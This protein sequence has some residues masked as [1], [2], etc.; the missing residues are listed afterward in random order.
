MAAK[1]KSAKSEEKEKTEKA[2]L[3]VNLPESSSFLM[4]VAIVV[5]AIVIS[6]AVIYTGSQITDSGSALGTKE[7]TADE[8][9][10]PSDNADNTIESEVAATVLREFETFTEYDTEIC[11]DDGKPIVYLFSTTWCPHCSWIKDTFESWAKENT[12]KV[13]AYHWELDIGDDTL[14]EEVESSVPDDHTAIY[15]K[16]NPGGSI[17]TFVFGCK[18]ARIG[19]GYEAEDDL[20]QERQTFDNILEKLSS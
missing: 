10:V 4:P 2:A 11:K 18:Y 16:F 6:V 3:E 1:K 20:D 12:D 9:S 15:E 7:E 8:D 5:S 19:N 17:P 13:V 14:T